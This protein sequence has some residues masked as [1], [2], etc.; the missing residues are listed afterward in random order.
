MGLLILV[1]HAAPAVDPATPAAD[2]PLSEKG[3]AAARV[4]GAQLEPFASKRLVSGDEPKMIGTAEAIGERLGLVNQPMGDLAEH[5]RRSTTFGDRAV[6]E[7]SIRALF[8]RPT[9]VV[10]GDESADQTCDRF[11]SAIDGVMAIHG[12][13]PV[14]AVSGGTAISVFMARRLGID[15]F[16]FW[17]TLKLPQA[18]VLSVAPW[19]LEST[20]G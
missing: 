18:F 19:R 12:E 8:S 6:F 17:K 7:V 16:P 2:W 1:R 5:A 13:A 11:A 15:P 10:Y 4:L 3:R 20:I 14:V 9:E